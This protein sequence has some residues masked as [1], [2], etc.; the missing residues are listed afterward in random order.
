MQRVQFI[1]SFSPRS[2]DGVT[3]S[4]AM[5]HMEYFILGPS[6]TRQ[7]CKSSVRERVC[8]CVWLCD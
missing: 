6:L 2:D 5:R 3:N 7:V 8:V 1:N 4:I